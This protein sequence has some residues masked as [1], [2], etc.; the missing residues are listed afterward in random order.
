MYVLSHD[1]INEISGGF[2]CGGLCV[3]I[4]FAA[5]AA[6]GGGVTWAILN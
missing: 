1:E 6:I 3:G 5:G 2:V 4:A